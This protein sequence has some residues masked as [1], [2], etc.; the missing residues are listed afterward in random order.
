MAQW[1]RIFAALAEDSGNSNYPCNS[2]GSNTFI[3]HLRAPAWAWS[4][5]IHADKIHACAYTHV[6]PSPTL[7][8]RPFLARMVVHTYH[9]NYLEAEEGELEVQ[10]MPKL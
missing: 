3:W 1:L 9:P 7:L 2:K 8:A 10:G 5:Y 4:R 6:H